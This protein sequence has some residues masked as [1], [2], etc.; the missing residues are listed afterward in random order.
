MILVLVQT[1]K[2]SFFASQVHYPPQKQPLPSVRWTFH[3][4]VQ[5]SVI[6]SLPLMSVNLLP[7][8]SAA[9]LAL[10]PFPVLP[11]L[12][13]YSAAVPQSAPEFLPPLVRVPSLPEP[14][15]VAV[16]FLRAQCLRAPPLPLRQ[17][18]FPQSMRKLP[19][20]P[21]VRRWL[22]PHTPLLPCWL[23]AASLRQL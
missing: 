9:V 4:Y 5:C 11:P 20:W 3:C 12:L 23:P 15:P 13:L 6:R 17:K 18:R 1:E 14:S 16:L 22:P 10:K 7:R 21:Q 8:S 19:P 2:H